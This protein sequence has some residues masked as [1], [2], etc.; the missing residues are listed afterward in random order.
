MAKD[1]KKPAAAEEQAE[2]VDP[3]ARYVVTDAEKAKARKWFARAEE[4]VKT[5]SYDYAVKCYIDGLALWPEAVDEGHQPLRGCGVARQHTG[6]KKSGFT[7]GVRHSMTNK[8]PLKAMLN[9]EWLLAHDPMNVGYME[10]LLKNANKARCEDTL[11]WVGSI[12]RH[13]AE[14][15]KKPSAKRFALLKDVYE[16]LGDRAQARGETDLAVQAFRLGIEALAIQAR[17][18]PKDTSLANVQRDLSTKLTILKGQYQTAESFTESIQDREGQADL[19]DEDRMV[20]SDERLEQ[21]IAKA[22]H[23]MAE[24]P[25]V[26]GKVMTLVE[27]LCRQ[28]NEERETKAIGILVQEFKKDG[29]Y[30]YKMRADDVRMRQLGRAYRQVRDSGDK[31]AAREALTRQ[32]RFELKVFGERVKKYPTD[33]RVRYE[34]GTRLFQARRIDDAIPI[35]QAARADPK[36]RTRCDLYLG[37]CFHEKGYHSQAAATLTKAVATYE[38]KED[39]TA[40]ALKYWLGRTQEAEG[41]VTDALATYGELLQIDYNYRDVRGRM[42]GLKKR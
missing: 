30:R 24:N 18:D 37:R 31:E 19:H 17:I 22:E 25:G 40:K 42:D 14:N 23:E 39:E 32:L 26:I 10:G 12:Y 27:L 15:E 9:A 35:F 34:Y 41:L 16:E 1:N 7:D 21:L 5:R 4:L 8:D 38:F 20:Q 3:N 33:L 6:G 29:E 11:M 13:A 2:E 28:D 36:N